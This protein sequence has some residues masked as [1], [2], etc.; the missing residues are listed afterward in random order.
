MNKQEII[1]RFIK[2][3]RIENYLNYCKQDIVCSLFFYETGLGDSTI[4]VWKVF[5]QAIIKVLDVNLRKSVYIP[6]VLSTKD[7]SGLICVTN[8]LQELS[9]RYRMMLS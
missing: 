8:N 5:Q 9:G 4:F 6:T 1:S 3:T 7:I 2:Q